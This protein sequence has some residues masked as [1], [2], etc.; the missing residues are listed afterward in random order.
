M[1]L[2]VFDAFR[3]KNPRVIPMKRFVTVTGSA[4]NGQPEHK[5]GYWTLDTGSPAPTFRREREGNA[6][7][8]NLRLIVVPR[9]FCLTTS[10]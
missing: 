7:G 9:T 10:M 2:T 8:A 6:D 3:H 5:A 4:L 1:I